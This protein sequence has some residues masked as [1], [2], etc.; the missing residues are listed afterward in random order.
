[1]IESDEFQG[2]SI[3]QK[4]RKGICVFELE[5]DTTDPARRS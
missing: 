3:S 5:G 4:T 1:M 2:A